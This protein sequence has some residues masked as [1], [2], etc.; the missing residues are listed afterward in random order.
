MPDLT[1]SRREFGLSFVALPALAAAPLIEQPVRSDEKQQKP[2]QQPNDGVATPNRKRDA[3]VEQLDEPRPEAT[4][5]VPEA[6]WLLGLILKRY[7]DE[8]IDEPAI[9]GI[10]G[11]IQGDLQRS[12]TLADFPL[13]NSDEPGLVFRPFLGQ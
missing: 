2:V 11:D 6:A 1:V 9:R 10:L 5:E 4:E 13:E 12:K 7:P 3:A 8:R